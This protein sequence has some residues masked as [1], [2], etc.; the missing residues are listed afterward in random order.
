[1]TYYKSNCGIM[2]NVYGANFELIYEVPCGSSL[3]GTSSNVTTLSDGSM[4]IFSATS[5]GYLYMTTISQKG[6]VLHPSV[7]IV[8]PISIFPATIVLN[9]DYVLV[10]YYH[11]NLESTV[12][13]ICDLSGAALLQKPIPS[14][15]LADRF[16]GCLMAGTYTYP[17][18]LLAFSND[19]GG[20]DD[21]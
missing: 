16:N 10:V 8:A 7:V 9:S 15:S 5:S 20:V 14:S 19:Y 4:I 13:L 11:K 6:V 18:M 2:Y 12:L 21:H 17:R 3:P 1:M